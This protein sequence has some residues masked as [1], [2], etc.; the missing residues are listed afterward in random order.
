[1][2]WVIV[3]IL[4]LY[5]LRKKAFAQEGSGSIPEYPIGQYPVGAENYITLIRVIAIQQG[6][7]PALI[8]A[9]ISTET[10]GTWNPNVGSQQRWDAQAGIGLMQVTKVGSR[11]VGY[12]GSWQGL[13]IPHTNIETGVAYFSLI[14]NELR[15]LFPALTS[16]ALINYTV[17]GY[18]AGRT[19][20]RDIAK[21]GQPIPNPDYLRSVLTNYRILKLQGI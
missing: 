17:A 3:S 21:S 9:I 2:T 8:A 19:K 4:G 18:N 14:Y 5:L 13:M 15:Q 6:F 7:E 16:I 11:D 20:I 1:M 10:G 12:V